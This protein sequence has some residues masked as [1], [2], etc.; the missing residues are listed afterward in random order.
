MRGASK[1]LLC[2]ALLALLSIPSTVL[3]QG[4]VQSGW[5]NS[6]PNLNGKLASGEWADATRVKLHSLTDN[7]DAAPLGD[8]VA[9][10]TLGEQVSAEQVSGWARFMNDSRYLYLAVSLDMGA[11]T[12]D[13]DYWD[14]AL[15][16]LFEDEPTIGDNRWAANLCSQNPDEGGYISASQYYPGADYD[17]DAF[18]AAS[19]DAWCWPG[20]HDPPG[21]WRALGW[22]STNLEVRF[23][24]QTSA[25]DVAPGDCFNAGIIIVSEEYYF[26]ED[27]SEGARAVWPA[28][29]MVADGEPNVPDALAEVCL[30]APE[31]FVPEPGSVA[32]LA[33]GLAGLGGYATLRWRARRKE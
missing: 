33:T 26:D 25:L 8:E 23:D 32:L 2:V 17:Y 16:F 9:G 3:S 12:G 27:W 19:E 30:A 18:V 29:L 10:L 15:Y 4:P 11:P 1:V 14:T 6:P 21:Y 5:T 28:E 24:L 20:Q 22:G 7:F 31:E 13:P